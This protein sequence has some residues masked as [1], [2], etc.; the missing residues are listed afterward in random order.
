MYVVAMWLLWGYYIYFKDNDNSV[1]MSVD[2]VALLCGCYLVSM[3]FQNGCYGVD[4]F[5]LC[6]CYVVDMWFLCG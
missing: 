6:G 1:L 5:F 2:V 4:T 3:W